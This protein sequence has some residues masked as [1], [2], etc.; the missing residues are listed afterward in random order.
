MRPY[1]NDYIA[2]SAKR[3]QKLKA[4]RMKEKEELEGEN[5]KLKEKVVF[6]DYQILAAGTALPPETPRPCR[7]RLCI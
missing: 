7:S 4:R 5:K 3:R 6:L 2:K 1:T